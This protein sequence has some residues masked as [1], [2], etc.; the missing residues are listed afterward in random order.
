MKNL[1]DSVSIS[2]RLQ[3]NLAIA[4]I[5][6]LIIGFSAY[7]AM[8]FAITQSQELIVNENELVEPISTFQKDY[9]KTIQTMNDTIIT[10]NE[11]KSVE[12]NQQIDILNKSL[13]SLLAQLGA[14]VAP[15]SDGLLEMN[16]DSVSQQN[17]PYVTELFK[18]DKVLFDI[19]K[20]TNSSLFLRKNMLSTFSFGLESNAKRMVKELSNI[21]QNQN[22]DS[23]N[24]LVAEVEKR[25]GFSQIQAAKMVTTLDVKLINEIR[26]K[27][28][29]DGVESTIRDIDNIVGSEKTEQLNK[30]RDD[31]LDAL[32]DLRDFIKTISENN[33]SLSKLSA[34]GGQAL[35]NI[36]ELLQSDRS[37]KYQQIDHELNQSQTVLLIVS[38]I[39]TLILFSVTILVIR[40]IITPLARMKE[41]L[42]LIVETGHLQLNKSV[43][44]KNELG[45]MED[46]LLHAFSS[47]KSAIEEVTHVSTQLS[48]GNLSNRMSEIYKGD[49]ATL[50]EHFNRSLRRLESTFAQIQETTQALQN[51]DLNHQIN[52]GNVEGQF[53]LLVE[54]LD[55]AMLVQKDAL[56]EVRHV[57]HAMRMG[58]FSQRIQTNMPGDL[59]D[60]KRYLNEALVLLEL[61]INEKSIMLNHLSSGDFTYQMTGEFHG[62][63]LELKD[64]M[65]QMTYSIADMLNHVQSAS[66]SAVHGI[67]E[68]SAGNQDLSRR[69]QKQASA[70]ASVN[71]EMNIMTASVND[72]LL[73]AQSVANNAESIKAM[74]SNG[75]NLIVQLAESIEQIRNSSTQVGKM[76]DVINGIAFQTNLL[77]LNAAVEAA[78]AG[79]HGRGFA[80]VAQEVRALANRTAETSQSIQKMTHQN[81]SL[82][83]HG[84][85]LSQQTVEA[86]SKN[87]ESI[88]Q[89]YSMTQKMNSSLERQTKGIVDVSRAIDDIDASTQ[90]NAAMVEEIAST[91]QNIINEVLQLEQHVQQFNL[92]KTF[93]EQSSIPLLSN[94]IH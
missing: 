37:S 28:I 26:E 4:F 8:Q 80:V 1:L 69:V 87:A 27:G 72:T 40:S 66:H 23:L 54:S 10:M 24:T 42:E 45:D 11:E 71:H 46:G 67:K 17:L 6:L 94:T 20:S 62:K 30:Y 88:E 79:E 70:L 56:T 31:Y 91:S 38:I 36:D 74:S 5:S 90:Q 47:I 43:L 3:A 16:V 22:N 68:V 93:D 48:H 60:L 92:P 76:T 81:L 89:I 59:N 52:H 58:D 21:T 83:S 15:N 44:G 12:F 2:K 25:I 14:E 84:L 41:S 32:S 78:R 82:I 51:G 57:T 86:F 85:E 29:G 77:A 55:Q 61:A 64:N 33:G 65:G 39:A 35:L 18:I 19:K 49:L 73:Q 9:A 13:L 63:L 7:S 75:Q 53:K 50:V 34:D